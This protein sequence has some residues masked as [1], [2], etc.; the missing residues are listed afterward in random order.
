[1][2]EN[3]LPTD[4]TIDQGNLIRVMIWS[5]DKNL[6]NVSCLMHD[7]WVAYSGHEACEIHEGYCASY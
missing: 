3:L 4:V 1:M 5:W 7:N 6:L 2:N